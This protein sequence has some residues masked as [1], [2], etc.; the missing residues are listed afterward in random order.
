MIF[1]K[2][3]RVIEAIYMSGH[4]KRH[5]YF[6][7]IN[8]FCFSCFVHKEHMVIKHEAEVVGGPL[9]DFKIT[10]LK[11]REMSNDRT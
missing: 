10:S 6:K 4:S 3:L 1:E 7:V 8:W 5:L 11:V 2:I 9:H